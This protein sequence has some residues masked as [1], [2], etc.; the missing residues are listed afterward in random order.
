MNDLALDIEVE[1]GDRV[2]IP[3]KEMFGIVRYIGNSFRKSFATR[4]VK[5]F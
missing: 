3:E 4:A 5:I 1:L 2:C